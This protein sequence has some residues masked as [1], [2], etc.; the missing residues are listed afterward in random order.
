MKDPTDDQEVGKG[1]ISQG[2]EGFHKA[3]KLNG[4]IEYSLPSV[5]K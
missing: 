1:F 5:F 2:A 4:L 3:L